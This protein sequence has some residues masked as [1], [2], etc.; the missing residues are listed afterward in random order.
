MLLG[1]VWRPAERA[2]T[3][4][5]AQG[6]SLVMAG[7]ARAAVALPTRRFVRAAVRLLNTTCDLLLGAPSL[8]VM[9]L[10]RR[11]PTTGHF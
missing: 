8:G 10:T 3:Y 6:L 5:T 9:T 2:D 7:F 11:G 1:A 4:A